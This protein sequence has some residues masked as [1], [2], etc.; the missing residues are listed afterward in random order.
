MTRRSTPLTPAIHIYR[1][2]LARVLVLDVGWL[3]QSVLGFDLEVAVAVP[4]RKTSPSRRNMRRSA[5]EQ[6]GLD[7]ECPQDR[8]RRASGWCGVR[9]AALLVYISSTTARLFEP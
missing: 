7:G 5:A 3:M 4:R 1:S 6:C 9:A 2:S 8:Q